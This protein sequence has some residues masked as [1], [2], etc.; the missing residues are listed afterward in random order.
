FVGG[1]LPVFAVG[2]IADKT[3]QSTNYD[4][5]VN[6][7]LTQGA[8]EMVMSALYKT[9]KA[10]LVER[11][12]LRIPIAEVKLAEQNRLNRPVSSFVQLPASDFIVV[13]ALTE[14]NFNLVTGG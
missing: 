4:H 3:G 12:D 9:G 5:E 13:G 2:E 11:Y 14:L 6:K 10:N 7:N 1:N 8:A